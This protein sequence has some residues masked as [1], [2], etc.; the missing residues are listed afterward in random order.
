MKTI[1]NISIFLI[2][3]IAFTVPAKA[4]MG[5]SVTP[6]FPENQQGNSGFYDLRITP[7]QEQ[8]IIVTVSNPTDKEIV[9][10][11]EAFT[12]S[13]AR[14]GTIDYSNA[15]MNDE[16][17][18]YSISELI[19]IP[20]P[21]V[22]IPPNSERTVTLRL[23]AP[24]ENFDGILLGSLRFLR[25]PTEEE[26]E[27]SGAIMN[28]YAHAMAIKLSMNDRELDA[29]FALGEITSQIT[30]AR[31]SIVLDVRN[32]VARLARGVQAQARIFELDNNNEVFYQSLDEVDFAPNSVFPF[33]M[34]DRAGYGISAGMYRADITL[35]YQGQ[36]WELSQEFEIAPTQAATVN[37]AARN[38]G[39]QQVVSM[40]N[41]GG[42]NPLTWVL[43]GAGALVVLVAVVLIIRQKRKSD[44]Q[45]LQMQQQI[46]DMQRR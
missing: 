3:V 18:P 1:R 46:L 23:T 32:P 38:Q 19:T 10:A 22:I 29:D 14:G 5:F 9:V 12:V 11:V 8:D 42:I 30:N 37:S 16:T 21:R 15:R 34:V 17:L 35:E 40:A 43:I 25:E 20:E 33:T 36:T 39:Q 24:N 7:G 2:M 13:T 6:H 26:V 45:W 31:A 4:S 28:R 27:A 44:E 41:R